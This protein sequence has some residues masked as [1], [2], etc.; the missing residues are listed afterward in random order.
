MVVTRGFHVGE[1]VRE[2]GSQGL[3]LYKDM[4]IGFDGQ[5][6]RLESDKGTRVYPVGTHFMATLKA[7]W[8]RHAD[9][10]V[11]DVEEDDDSVRFAS[12]WNADAHPQTKMRWLRDISSVSLL[13]EIR[14]R[15]P[16]FRKYIDERM[17][18]LKDPEILGK[19]KD[20]ED[21]ELPEGVDFGFDIKEMRSRL[22]SEGKLR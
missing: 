9:N 8:V 1:V 5:S 19:G 18:E 7:G 16:K 21:E 4:E 13:G 15:D 12:D 17:L 2:G 11:E 6:I 14:D 3:D 22:R 20:P 10:G